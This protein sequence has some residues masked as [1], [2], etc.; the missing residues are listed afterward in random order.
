MD[1]IDNIYE[2]LNVYGIMSKL[3]H[4]NDSIIIESYVICRHH[5]MVQENNQTY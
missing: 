1:H 4:T 3:G 5:E 2:Y